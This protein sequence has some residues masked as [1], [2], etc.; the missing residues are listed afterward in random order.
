[1]SARV[2]ETMTGG[3]SDRLVLPRHLEQPGDHD[4]GKGSSWSDV[5]WRTI[6]AV[7]GVVLG[8]YVT[9]VLLLASVR[10]I[11]WVL[12]AGFFAI[13][14][15]PLVKRV[16]RHVRNRRA[17]A[18]SIVVF[19]TL[20]A[21]LGVVAL[22]IMPVRTQ[23]VSILTDLPGTVHDAAQGKGPV[24]NLVEKLHLESLVRKNESKLTTAANKLG[25]S[26]FETATTILSG[27]LAFV[28]ITLITFL[29]LSQSEAM[30]RAATNLIPHRRRASVRRIAVEAAGAVSGYVIGNLLVSVVAGVAAFVCLVSLGVPS[31]VV[32]AL[33]VAFADLIPLV[34][35]TL[36]AAVSVLAAFLYSPTAGIVSLIF[37]IV[38]QQVENG[39]IYPQIMARKVNVNPLVI[40]LS[41]LV[42]VE[43][44]GF[45]GALLAVPASGAL[46]VII[47]AAR[48]EH[49][50]EQLVLPDNVTQPLDLS[51]R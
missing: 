32:L 35:A 51:D 13:V 44:F 29:F 18:T 24:G 21:M 5:P 1:M 43:L 30:G 47:K 33:F 31:P 2:H 27:A 26:T 6:V 46:Q 48:Q 25:D 11:A 50:R 23:L 3:D 4:R 15:A 34:G 49:G 28:T 22:F 38:Y 14:L 20:I 16:Q 10:V 19:S 42:G 17:V 9:C 12:V 36:G 39:L 45:L 41:V 8:T 7:V 40:L 37:F